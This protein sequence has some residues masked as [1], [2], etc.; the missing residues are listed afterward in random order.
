M[1]WYVHIYVYIMHACPSPLH[2]SV[3][4]LMPV[5]V[6]VCSTA[7]VDSEHP[8][9]CGKRHPTKWLRVTQN[10]RRF[11]TK[12]K[13]LRR[14]REQLVSGALT[15][16]GIDVKAAELRAVC[17]GFTAYLMAKHACDAVVRPV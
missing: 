3:C 9:E 17:S 15:A 1:Y 5:R 8:E 13:Y 14:Q 10:Q 12:A 7:W 16:Q 4:M 2:M 6:H 11:D